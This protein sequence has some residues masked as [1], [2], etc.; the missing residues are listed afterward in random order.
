MLQQY[1]KLLFKTN[2]FRKSQYLKRYGGLHGTST[3][4]FQVGTDYSKWIC[5]LKKEG[6]YSLYRLNVYDL[7]SYKLENYYDIAPSLFECVE[8]KQ[9]IRCLNIL[10]KW[11]RMNRHGVNYPKWIRIYDD[12]VQSITY[13]RNKKE[14][15]R[16]LYHMDEPQ[17]KHST[18]VGSSPLKKHLLDRLIDKIFLIKR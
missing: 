2:Q 8:S 4:Q 10:D 16:R 3:Y 11:N 5:Y 1:L 7:L 18:Y 13:V 14:L 15:S 6:L 17:V 9:I 12:Y